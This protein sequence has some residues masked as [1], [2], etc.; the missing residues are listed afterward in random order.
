VNVHKFTHTTRNK[1]TVSLSLSVRCEQIGVW[2]GEPSAEQP[3]TYI[4]RRIS[5]THKFMWFLFLCVF[6][7]VSGNSHIRAYIYLGTYMQEQKPRIKGCGQVDT[8][9][10]AETRLN[11]Y[12]YFYMRLGENLNCIF[13]CQRKRYRKGRCPPDIFYPRLSAAYRCIN[14]SSAHNFRP[15]QPSDGRSPKKIGAVI[16]FL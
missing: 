11:A 5:C 10:P 3:S 1:T 12:T 13:L 2:G 8:W 4:V 14:G 9:V 16:I 15:V 7:R 6:M